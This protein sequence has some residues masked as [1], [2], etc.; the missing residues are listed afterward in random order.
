MTNYESKVITTGI[1][2]GDAYIFVNRNSDRHQWI[3]NMPMS[4][5][6]SESK[7]KNIIKDAINKKISYERDKENGTKA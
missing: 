6:I 2:S 4:T 5:V 1:L 7:N 3:T